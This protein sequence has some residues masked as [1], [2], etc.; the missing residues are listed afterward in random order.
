MAEFLLNFSVQIAGVVNNNF[1]IRI[2]HF[3]SIP[4]FSGYK[5]GFSSL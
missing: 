3:L 2:F 4:Y 1:V 5:T